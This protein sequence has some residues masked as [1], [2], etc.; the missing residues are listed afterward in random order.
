MGIGGALAR[1]LAKNLAFNVGAKASTKLLDRIQAE[2]KKKLEAM[3]KKGMKKHPN[4]CHLLMWATLDRKS[5]YFFDD[6][7]YLRYTARGLCKGGYQRVT[8]YDEN[9]KVIGAIAEKTRLRDWLRVG[10]SQ[11]EFPSTFQVSCYGNTLG[12]VRP[13][14]GWRQRLVADFNGWQ[15]TSKN[16][17][18]DKAGK[19][20]AEIDRRSSWEVPLAFLSYPDEHFELMVVLLHLANEAYFMTCDWAYE[21]RQAAQNQ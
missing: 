18:V 5:Y 15:V 8:L 11:A 1:M 16:A 3:R 9:S 20:M 21:E 19:V 12:F 7:D 10:S 17:I 6:N 13:S 14:N 2:T 4:D